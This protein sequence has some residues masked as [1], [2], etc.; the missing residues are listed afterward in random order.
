[1]GSDSARKEPNHA[2]LLAS[3]SSTV[4]LFRGVFFYLSTFAELEDNSMLNMPCE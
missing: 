4:A 1:M 2:L 3:D